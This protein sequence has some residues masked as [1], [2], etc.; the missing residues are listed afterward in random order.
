MKLKNPS[1]RFDL[2]IK[3]N[4][5]VLEVGGGH[6]PNPRANVIVDKFV[7]SNYHRSGDIKVYNH[8][9]FLNADG[10]NLPFEDKSFDY[11]ICAQVLEHVNDPVKFLNEQVR[12]SPRGY[13]ETPSII[14]EFLIPKESHRWLLQEIDGKIV[15]YEKEQIDFRPTLDFGYVFQEFL[16]KNSIGF[17]I[18]Q[19][20]HSDLTLMKYEWTDD[21]EV[22]VN[23]VSSYYKDFFT[24]PWSEEVCN[25]FLAKRTLT[26]EGASSFHAFLGICKSVFRSKI[27]TRS[28]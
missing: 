20:T 9:Q 19:D 8:Q 11:V 18:M 25:K 24:K 15:M 28:T 27:L 17:K 16:P 2:S 6:N 13:V 12:V 26:K 23:P 10:E 21:I 1:S 5:K 7:D 3:G 4:Y 22:L 14:G